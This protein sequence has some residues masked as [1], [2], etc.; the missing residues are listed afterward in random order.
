MTRS[1][2]PAIMVEQTSYNYVSPSAYS[3]EYTGD[4]GDNSFAF[5]ERWLCVERSMHD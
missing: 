1:A 4:N 5:Q 3:G 2:W